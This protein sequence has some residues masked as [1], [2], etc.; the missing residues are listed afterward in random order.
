MRAHWQAIILLIVVS[1]TGGCEAGYSIGDTRVS[2]ESSVTWIPADLPEAIEIMQA[3]SGV[4]VERIH[5]VPAWAPVGHAGTACLYIPP[6]LIRARLP[7]D[8]GPAVTD[9]CVPHEWAHAWTAA[10]DGPR[11]GT[12]H[13]PA[14]R[15]RERRL[16]AATAETWLGLRE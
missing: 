13:G 9:S 10:A 15:A 3:E 14:W 7:R 4:S 12:E 2:W 1:T 11:A 6:G 5:V 8:H 16:R